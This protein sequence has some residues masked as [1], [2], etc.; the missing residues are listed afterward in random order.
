MW[1]CREPTAP[2]TNHRRTNAQAS[3]TA[4]SVL[5]GRV[6]GR[7]HPSLLPG[8]AHPSFLPEERVDASCG[9]P[10]AGIADVLN[11]LR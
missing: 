4:E 11:L 6:P 9:Y 7:A 8:R 10:L 2:S 1:A 3:G 5:P